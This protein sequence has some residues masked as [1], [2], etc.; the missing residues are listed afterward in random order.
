MDLQNLAPVLTEVSMNPTSFSLGIIQGESEGVL[1]GYEFEIVIPKTFDKKINY[2]YYKTLILHEIANPERFLLHEIILDYE[3]QASQLDKL[4]KIKDSANP[5][6]SSFKE[7]FKTYN[8][9]NYK[10][11]WNLIQIIFPNETS[12]VTKASN[13]KK[14][15]EKYFEILNAKKLVNW[16]EQFLEDSIVFREAEDDKSGKFIPRAY[17]LADILKSEFNVDVQIFDKYHQTEKSLDRWYIEPDRSI[18]PDQGETGLEIVTPPLSPKNSIEVLKKFFELSKKYNFKTAKKYNTGLHINVS[19]PKKL[20]LTKLILFLGDTYLL[21]LFDRENNEYV[22]NSEIEFDNAF[23]YSR[24]ELIKIEPS[25]KKNIVFS[26]KPS[27]KTKFSREILDRVANY[28]SGEHYSSVSN[29]EKYISF[30]HAGG[31]YLKDYQ[32]IFNIVGRFVR[33]MIIASDPNLYKKEY[34]TKLAKLA[35]KNELKSSIMT[36]PFSIGYARNLFN[37]Y[38]YLKTYGYPVLRIYEVVDYETYNN[39]HLL[40]E[41]VKKVYPKLMPYLEFF[42]N[43]ERYLR[44]GNEN[45]NK[46]QI[47]EYLSKLGINKNKISKIMK[48]NSKYFRNSIAFP[49]WYH[50]PDYI[51]IIKKLPTENFVNDNGNYFLFKLDHIPIDDPAVKMHYTRPF[52]YEYKQAME[53]IKN[54][55]LNEAKQVP[56]YYFAYGMLT[57]P[58]YLP[59]AELLGVGELRNFEF[60]LYVYAN[61][62]PKTGAKVYGALWKIDRNLLGA[63]DKIEAY[64]ELYDRRTYP[65]YLNGKK[66]PAEVYLMTPKTLEYVEGTLPKQSYINTLVKGYHNAGIPIKQIQNALYKEEFSEKQLSETLDQPYPYS[67]VYE[68]PTKSVYKFT[69]STGLDYTV[70]FEGSNH[71][72]TAF[73]LHKPNGSTSTFITNTGDSFRV[74]STVVKIIKRFIKE[75]SPNILWF[76]SYESEPSRAKLYRTIIKLLLRNNSDYHFKEENFAGD[77]GFLLIKNK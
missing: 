3:R 30:R 42:S 5:A 6:V 18:E 2:D 55:K 38:Q 53:K 48:D 67:L 61:V 16:V 15:F 76:S 54:L 59:G 39:R 9:S 75:Y 24:D 20:D 37:T 63:L 7:A 68:T 41:Q 49:D 17:L 62:E 47:V 72:S 60:N 40:G 11:L 4:I 13:L 28:I 46:K 73:Y 77:P 35:N 34:I 27:Q 10:S 1:V 58:D 33:A 8:V 32:S 26:N 65:V 31:D 14:N 57:D 25:L 50:L 19:I 51:N 71:V 21:K 43:S 23:K 66:Y 45:D 36:Q 12:T 74:I 29:N 56:I 52:M 64:P 22:R 70:E 44:I 69:T